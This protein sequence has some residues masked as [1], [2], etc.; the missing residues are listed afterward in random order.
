MTMKHMKTFFRLNVM[1]VL[2]LAL[3]AFSACVDDEQPADPLLVHVGDSLPA[4]RVRLMDGSWLSRDSLVGR[5]SVVV[6]FNT[7]C[8]DCRRELPVVDS[9][10]VRHRAETGVRFVAIARAEEA[11]SIWAFWDER[12]LTIP[13]SA[14]ADRSVYN[15]F[16]TS[17]VPRLFLSGTDGIV[18]FAHDDQQM[19]DLAQLEREFGQLK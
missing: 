17:V 11:E 13:F 4:F 2:V 1:G 9:L 16:A 15:L 6:L 18:R 3:T 14:Q 12:G 8:G 5:R 10:Y 7:G 19:P